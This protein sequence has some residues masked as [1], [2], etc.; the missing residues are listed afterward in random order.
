MEQNRW[1]DKPNN[2]KIPKNIDPKSLQHPY[3]TWK[4]KRSK[5]KNL[6]KPKKTKKTP[7]LLDNLE[8]IKKI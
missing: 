8:E 6:L 2:W 1:N 3:P 7:N 4:K 5:K